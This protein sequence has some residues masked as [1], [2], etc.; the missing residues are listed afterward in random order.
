MNSPEDNKASIVLAA[1][2]RYAPGVWVAIWST[3]KHW[4]GDFPPHFYLLTNDEADLGI[5]R[6]RDLSANAGIRLDIHTV[7]TR[8]FEALHKARFGHIAFFR[9]L[10]PQILC[11]RREFLYLDADVFSRVSLHPLFGSKSAAIVSA[12]CEYGIKN[13]A[14]GLHYLPMNSGD[15]ALNY[16]NSGILRVNVRAWNENNTTGQILEFLHQHKDNLVGADQD[17]IN[18][19]LRGKIEELD[20]S[21]NF[22]VGAFEYLDRIRWPVERKILEGRR[23]DLL[24]NARIVH[25]VFNP[26]KPWLKYIP[27]DYADQYR[28]VFFSSGWLTSGERVR[29]Q[30]SWAPAALLLRMRK[31]KRAV[32]QPANGRP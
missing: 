1:N 9:L 8:Q 29:R 21:W 14:S 5:Q 28:R 3:W 24:R 10:A 22:Q 4:E 13:L 16:F 20:F 2:G 23:L 27:D 15:A 31:L 32:L 26:D 25:Y 18:F 30:L 6:V 19:V 12:V 7:E 11:E 17:G